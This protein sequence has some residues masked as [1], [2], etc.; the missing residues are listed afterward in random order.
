MEGYM[1]IVVIKLFRNEIGCS[2]YHDIM[3]EEYQEKVEELHK[4]GEERGK[5]ILFTVCNSMS[6]IEADTFAEVTSNYDIS[7]E[8][9]NYYIDVIK[10]FCGDAEISYRT[11][12]ITFCNPIVIFKK[13]DNIKKIIS[14][15]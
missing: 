3:I 4:Y 5:K 11:M 15:N 9:E 14:V 10:F 8:E 2:D 13:V 6:P 7:D 12:D 1:D